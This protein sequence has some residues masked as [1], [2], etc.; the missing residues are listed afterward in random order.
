MEDLYLSVSECTSSLWAKVVE[1]YTTE[2]LAA[3]LSSF[4]VKIAMESWKV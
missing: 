2:P 4:V 1:T 3:E